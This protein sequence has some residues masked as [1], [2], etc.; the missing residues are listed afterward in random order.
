MFLCVNFIYVTRLNIIG[1]QLKIKSF[2]W[3]K[4]DILNAK[5]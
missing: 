4:Y 2:L 3:L 5:L 1:H